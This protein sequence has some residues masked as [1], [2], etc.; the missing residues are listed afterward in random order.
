MNFDPAIIKGKSVAL[1][2]RAASIHEHGDGARID[3]CDLVIRVNWLHPWEGDPGRI[4]ARTDCIIR[5]STFPQLAQ[6][7]AQAGIPCWKKE[8]EVGVAQA[9]RCG[10]DP[11]RVNPRTGIH[12]IEMVLRRAPSSVYLAGYDLYQ[13]GNAT[14]TAKKEAKAAARRKARKRA[15]RVV[16]KHCDAADEAILRDLLRRYQDCIEIDAVLRER[17]SLTEQEES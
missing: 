12:A 7:A 10:F 13:S 15:G 4:G 8:W 1:I 6:A 14:N 3:A 5:A 9:K 2:G 17:L 16:R 11:A